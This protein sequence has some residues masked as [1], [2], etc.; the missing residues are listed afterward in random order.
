MALRP[1]NSGRPGSAARR[2]KAGLRAVQ[3]TGA[4]LAAVL[5]SSCGQQSGGMSVPAVQNAQSPTPPASAAPPAPS[6]GTAPAASASG[7]TEPQAPQPKPQDASS[8]R[9]HTSMLSGSLQPGEPGAGQRY[10][11]LVLTNT[12]GETCN[13]YGYG[14]LQ[15]IGADGRPLPTDLKRTPNPGPTLIRLA[16]GKSASA[17]L[18]WTAVPHEGEPT[19]GQCQPTPVRAEVIPPD[20]TEPLSVTWD[21]GEVCGFG[22]IDGS[23][24][25]S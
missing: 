12:S 8:Q 5:L 9:C 22:S 21:L 7:K 19:D 2:G 15:L 16:P 25:H 18:H 10:A 14:G 23:A 11:E 4:V 17:T 3:A 6:S 24:Y 1:V 20:E 13:L